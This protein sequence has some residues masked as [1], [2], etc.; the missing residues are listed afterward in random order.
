MKKIFAALVAG[1]TLLLPGTMASGQTL[2]LK[3][4]QTLL[5]LNE[6]WAAAYHAKTP[7]V[8]VAVTGE[9]TS[10][11]IT[12]LAGKKA[13]LIILPR[14][15]HY[16]ESQACEAAFG[17]RPPESK[18]AVSG[19][20]VYL[21]ANNPLKSLTYDELSDIVQGQTQNWKDLDGGLDQPVS[22][23]A[24]DTNTFIGE[25][26]NE[27]VLNGRGFPPSVHP[28]ANADLLQ[29]VAAAPGG[30]GIGA[31][32]AADGVQLP[33]IKRVRSSTPVI[34]SADKISRRIYPISRY[35][36]SY[37]NPAASPDAVK[38]YLAWIRSDEGQQIARQSGFYELP[39]LV[40]SSP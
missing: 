4:S 39:A 40:R 17:R 29:A 13:D 38:A 31:L 7:A 34:P 25:L 6:K 12:D 2:T 14:A 26:F 32:T 36:F 5:G 20:A 35:V 22:V 19:V 16:R 24:Q 21:N 33:G 3:S 10:A 18:V 30:I 9:E 15:L 1:M 23:Y 37:A 8:T 11:A 28:A 27:E